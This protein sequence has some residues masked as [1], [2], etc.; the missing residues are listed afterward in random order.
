MLGS[1]EWSPRLVRSL[2]ALRGV[3]EPLPASLEQEL[4]LASSANSTPPFSAEDLVLPDPTPMMLEDLP[5]LVHSSIMSD[6][7][8]E[9]HSTLFQFF[10]TSLIGNSNIGPG[11]LNWRLAL[12]AMAASL[13][14]HLID[15]SLVLDF[16]SRRRS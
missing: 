10:L 6:A 16:A 8:S 2:L 9:Q 15:G 13:T 1:G 4:S 3:A 12:P 7:N 14:Q 11:S 5:I